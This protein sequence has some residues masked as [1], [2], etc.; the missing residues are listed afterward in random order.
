MVSFK[1]KYLILFFI[2]SFAI[3]SYT[4]AQENI[5]IVQ[6]FDNDWLFLKSDVENAQNPEFDDT[7]WRKLNVPHDWSIE[8]PYDRTNPTGRGGGYLPAG[9]GWYRKQFTIPS[10]YKNRRVFIEFDGIMANSDVYING[11]HIGKRP[12]GYISFSYELTDHINYGQDN[13][14]V[15]AVRVDNSQQ[16]SSRWYS[17][18]GIYRHV[19]LVITEPIHIA[20]WGVF[21]STPAVVQNQSIVRI[22]TKI[23][24]QSDAQQN[25]KLKTIILDSAG[26]QIEE[27]EDSKIINTNSSVDFDQVCIVKNPELWD[28]NN[29]NLYKVINKVFIGDKLVDD[30]L[31]AFGIRKTEWKPDSG[32]WLNDRNLKIK[33]VCLHHDAGGL[34]TAVP[35]SAWERRLKIL[36]SLGV[37]AIRVGHSPFA[38]EF[39]DLCDK[40]GFLVM[41]ETFDT[42]T[43][44]KPNGE[45]GYNLYFKDNWEM[46]TRD[47]ILR[48]RNHPSI[49]IYSI[50]NEIRDQLS[51]EIGMQTAL[52]LRD[53][54]KKVDS[55]RPVTLAVFRPNQYHVYDS[56]FSELLDIVGQNYRENELIAAHQSK[57]ERIV[58]GTENQHN[59]QTWLVLR[60]NAFMSGQFLWTGI[61]YLGE[62]DWPNITW[63]TA[64]LDRTGTPRYLGYERQSWWSEKPM[65]H[66]VRLETITQPGSTEIEHVSN[67]TPLNS[68]S[69]TNC[70]LEIYSNCEQVELFLND[71]SL[72]TKPRNADDSPQT[73]SMPYKPGI[74]K[75]I[76]KNNSR[77][78][79]E[80]ILQTA[81]EPAKVQL[82]VER[83]EL[84]NEWNDC[85]YV[86]VTIVDKYGITCP[87]CDNL[88]TFDLEGPG[89]IAAVDNGDITSHEPYQA[90]QRK[91][92]Q[93]SCIAIIKATA[94]SGD[95]IISAKS[96]GLTEASVTI[97]VA[98]AL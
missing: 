11:Q 14:N 19:R 38:P 40:L 97:K 30:N 43:V 8:G 42:W 70:N 77:K 67:Y 51:S 91:A 47:L 63:G 36:K 20:H 10:D 62:A 59:R 46:D 15:L 69:Y 78:V 12:Y 82:S 72:G 90:K 18:A 58:I 87:W 54:I 88:I 73:W 98:P 17:G 5:R 86:T 49:I 65:V 89:I 52:G 32:F 35:L 80:H 16:P 21:V 81:G 1:S 13:N 94:D 7:S 23:E 71:E 53:T 3:S 74:L 61:D 66:I 92:Y 68:D 27:K 37:N 83:N 44:A 31:T 29:P 93:G 25:L 6:S 95:I 33:G 22:Q 60:D 48:D 57:P 39:Y 75:A 50:G 55:T 26:K 85:L 2:F 4:I 96:S 9:I 84:K 56:G 79:A 45:K 64:L 28:I 34:G 24:N 76:G 41:D